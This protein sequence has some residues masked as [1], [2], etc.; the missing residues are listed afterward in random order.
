MTIQEANAVGVLDVRRARFEV[1]RSLGFK[2]LG[3]MA[4]ALDPSDKDGGIQIA[5]WKNLFGMYQP[6]AIA[7]YQV[8]GK[9]LFVTANEGD[10]RELYAV[11]VLPRERRPAAIGFKTA[12]VNRVNSIEE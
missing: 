6:D 10:V 1:V 4:N 11:A 3:K 5:P 12:E 8:K 7:S 9:S 2:D